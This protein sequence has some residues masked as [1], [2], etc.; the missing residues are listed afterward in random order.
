LY[1]CC[2]LPRR[3]PLYRLYCHRSDREWLEP[4]T[5][6]VALVGAAEL[7][8]PIIQNIP[9]V[10][11]IRYLRVAWSH[12]F[13]R[14]KA[15]RVTYDGYEPNGLIKSNW[16]VKHKHLVPAAVVFLLE[17]DDSKQWDLQEGQLA[18]AIARFLGNNAGYEYR[19]MA[20]VVK[21]RTANDDEKT[22]NEAF[23]RMG[24]K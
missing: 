8:N 13:P 9:N 11:S 19:L 4:S 23:G 21:H 2:S 3:C 10:H 6:L 12:S 1:G 16:L 18:Q 20:V 22:L 14:R 17:W 24:K 5:P 7:Q 15:K